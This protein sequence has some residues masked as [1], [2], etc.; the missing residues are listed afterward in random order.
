MSDTTVEAPTRQEIKDEVGFESVFSDS[1]PNGGGDDVTEV[2]LRESDRTH[3][4]VCYFISDCGS[5]NG[6][7]EVPYCYPATIVQVK[8]VTVTILKYIPVKTP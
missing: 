2:F 6:L 4:R 8:P 1:E 3:W 7:A 5:V